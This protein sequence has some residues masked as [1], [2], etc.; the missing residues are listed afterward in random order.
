[1]GLNEYI[2]A[3]KK[4]LPI[5]KSVSEVVLVHHND[6]DGLTSAAIIQTAL[7]RKGIE[8]TDITL[9]RAHPLIIERIIKLYDAPIIFAD[10]GAGAAKVIS[11]K[12][13]GKNTIIII[14]HHLPSKVDDPKILNL[15][16]RAYDV[17]GDKDISASTAAYLFANVLGENRDLAYLAVIGAI[18]DSHHRFGKLVGANRLALEEA[19]KRNQVKV[20]EVDGKEDYYLTVFGGSI[21]ISKFAKELTV[22]GAVGYYMGGPDVGIKTALEGPNEEAEKLLEK[23]DNIKRKAFDKVL[24]KLRTEGLNQTEYVQWF[25]VHDDFAPMGVKVIGEF[26]MEIRDMD[27]IN[28]NKYLAGFQNMPPTVPKLG[29]FNWKLVKVSFR[30]PSA[31]EER[32]IKGEMPGYTWLVSKAAPHVGGDIDACHRH[33]CATTFDQGLEKEFIKWL[34]YYVNEYLKLARIIKS[35]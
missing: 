22:L 13:K 14:D 30:L 35:S 1:M 31:L 21:P 33:A 3:L 18:G 2:N 19:V 5:L 10:M 32:V 29:E 8:V 25:H 4:T 17:N 9:E 16:T 23:L 6:A 27:F 12:N 20:V 34:N 24:T 15:S 7:K 28:P 26:C 11:E